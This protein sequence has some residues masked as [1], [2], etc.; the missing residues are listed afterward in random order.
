[1]EELKILIGCFLAF[2]TGLILAIK[3]G[4]ALYGC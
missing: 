2:T 3:L 1:M 4:Q